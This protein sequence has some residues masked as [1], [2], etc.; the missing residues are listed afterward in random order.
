M[1][2]KSKNILIIIL[3]TITVLLIGIVIYLVMLSKDRT[4]D[5]IGKVIVVGSDYVIIENSDDD[6][7]VQ[8]IDQNYDVGDEIKVTYKEREFN[9]ETSPKTI[10]SKDS[11][12]IKSCV[13][14][15]D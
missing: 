7:L 10:I 5:I 4:S 1:S 14:L 8:N 15:Y 13:K 11:I 12:L 9:D 2:S 6:Y 3:S